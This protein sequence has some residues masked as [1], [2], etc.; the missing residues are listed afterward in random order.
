MDKTSLELFDRLV[1]LDTASMTPDEKDF[2]F[3]RRG[4]LNKSQRE[5]F[6]DLIAEGDAK[7][8]ARNTQP[9]EAKEE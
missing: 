5:Q 7:V 8:K 1:K 3:A 9:E 6:K 4:Y 2:L